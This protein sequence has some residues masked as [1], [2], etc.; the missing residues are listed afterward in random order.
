MAR[1]LRSSSTWG[2]SG[3]AA[4]LALVVGCGPGPTQ[5]ELTIAYFALADGRVDTFEATGGLTEE[6]T[7]SEEDAEAHIYERI[8]RRSGF[9][10]DDTTFQVQATDRSMDIVRFHDC[11]TLCGDFT[12]PIV[13]LERPLESGA[14]KETTV[15]VEVTRNGEPDGTREE[16]H[17]FQVGTE[18]EVT[19]PYG[20]FDGFPVIWSRTIDGTSTSA[21]LVFVPEEGFVVVETFAGVRYEL[22][23][24]EGGEPVEE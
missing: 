23:A 1:R 22:A 3:G 17:R 13:M 16:T 21:N 5:E 8:V 10:D 9:I 18:A 24:R 7:W 14:S 19:V 11:I 2:S 12:E 20:T 15:T 6:H 4:L